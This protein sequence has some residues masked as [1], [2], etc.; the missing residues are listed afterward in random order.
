MSTFTFN[1][2]PTDWAKDSMLY[3]SD[4]IVCTLEDGDYLAE[5]GIYDVRKY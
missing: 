5:I 1:G 2:A 4:T 3:D